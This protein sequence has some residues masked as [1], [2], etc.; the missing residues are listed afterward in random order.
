MQLRNGRQDAAKHTPNVHLV[1]LIGVTA[2]GP[3]FLNILI[4]AVP[5]LAATLTVSL[6]TAQLTISLF[7][8]GLAVSQ[9]IAGPLSDR[10]GRK[11]VMMIGLAFACISSLAVWL[12]PF[13]EVLIVAR[14]VQAL[15]VAAGAVVCNAII[16][17]V[18]DRDRSAVMIALVT[19]GMMLSPMLSPLLGGL[20]DSWL[21]WESI[22][23]ILALISIAMIVWIYT[24]LR[25]TK[26][27]DVGQAGERGNFR[28]MATLILNPRFLGYVGCGAFVSGPHFVFLSGAP[29]YII[30]SLGR[31]SAEY[32]FWSATVSF[33]YLM[34]NLLSAKLTPRVGVDGMIRYGGVLAAAGPIAGILIFHVWPSAG[35]WAVVIPQMIS[36]VGNGLALPCALSG[37]L[38]VRPQVA[39]AASGFA[40][41]AMMATG[42]IVVQAVGFITAGGFSSAFLP[43]V[44]LFVCALMLVSYWFLVRTHDSAHVA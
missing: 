17:D 22:F 41:S 7:L 1:L 3:G 40:G 23:L 16:R 43:W 15:G 9:I 10:Y 32:G 11:P 25:E 33:A 20:I 29:H 38:S 19:S 28:D 5:R 44:G 34:G 37:A 24:T 42:A 6:A 8:F 36:N 14:W 39:G 18:F 27:I 2:L 31:S 12:F 30:I 26:S 4:P 13:I 35:P 21:G